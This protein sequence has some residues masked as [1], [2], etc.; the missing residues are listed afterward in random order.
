MVKAVAGKYGKVVITATTSDGKTAKCNVMVIRQMY[1]SGGKWMIDSKDFTNQEKEAYINNAEE[2]C[3]SGNISNYPECGAGKFPYY[4]NGT[5]SNIQKR[6]LNKNV[7]ISATKYLV[8]TSSIKQTITL[9]EKK[10]STWK[11]VHSWKTSTG[12]AMLKGAYRFD[13]YYGVRLKADSYG[14]GTLLAQFW[15]T[16]TGSWTFKSLNGPIKEPHCASRAIHNGDRLAD[17]GS[18]GYPASAGCLR[19]KCAD[20]KILD[21]QIKNYYG[22]RI[23]VY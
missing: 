15:Q 19:M 6:Y 18:Y 2:L 21:N 10:G 9:M 23:I 22:T 12:K 3:H 1:Q 14:C 8:F 7:G 11:V 13:F 17:G 16:Q 20:Y 4:V 5:T